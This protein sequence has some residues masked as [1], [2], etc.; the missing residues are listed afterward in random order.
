MLATF[1][2]TNNSLLDTNKSNIETLV[3]MTDSLRSLH[4]RIDATSSDISTI[5]EQVTII[6]TKIDNGLSA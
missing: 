3:T 6:N 4:K 5:K 2:D 1:R